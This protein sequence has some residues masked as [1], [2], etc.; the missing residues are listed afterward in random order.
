MSRSGMKMGK[1]LKKKGFLFEWK[2]DYL[3]RPLAVRAVGL[4]LFFSVRYV[5]L[6]W[7]LFYEEPSLFWWQKEKEEKNPTKMFSD[8]LRDQHI[9]WDQELNSFI[10][11]FQRVER[12]RYQSGSV[13]DTSDPVF[14]PYNSK[15]SSR[16][17][18]SG[19]RILSNWFQ[20]FSSSP[21]THIPQDNARANQAR[22]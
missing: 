1:D 7:G 12:W 5:H 17:V 8:Q 9:S 3:V 15:V 21:F 16:N 2:S 13:T 6:N 10:F 4:A 19:I 22:N 20:P 18:V 11:L 14:S